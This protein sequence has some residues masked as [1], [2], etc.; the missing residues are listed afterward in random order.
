VS[1]EYSTAQ[2]AK[3]LAIGRATLH[4]WIS[5]DKMSGRLRA[6]KLLK[7][8]GISVRIW[9]AADVDRALL[10]KE[11]NYHKGIGRKPKR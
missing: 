8:G 5:G 10:F 2:V 3:L 6:P 4:R 11:K 9:T 1:K 7:V